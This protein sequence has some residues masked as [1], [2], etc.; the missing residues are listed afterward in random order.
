MAKAECFYMASTQIEP[1]QTAGEIQAFL[2]K[3]GARQILIDYGQDGEIKSL[4]FMIEIQGKMIPY[5]LPIR[6]ENCLQAMKEDRHTPD[7]Y[8]NEAQAKRTAWRIALRWV[9]AQF[10]FVKTRMVKLPEVMLPFVHYGE[11]T[12]FERLEK[13][14]FKGMPTLIEFQGGEKTASQFNSGRI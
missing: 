1:S 11:E 7:K 10:A 9:E 14:G 5:K 12:F 3:N 4:S 8:C 6:W 2:A 13:G